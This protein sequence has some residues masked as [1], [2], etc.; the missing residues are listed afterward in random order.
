MNILNLIRYKNLLMIAIVQLLI[1]YALFEPFGVAITLNGFGFS[2][3]VIATL[4]LAAGGNIINDIYDKETDAINKPDKVIVGKTVSEK[5]AYNLFIAFNVIGVGVGFYLSHLVGRSGFFVLFVGI[6]GLLYLYA[7]YF[8]QLILVG[9]LLVSILVA[10]SI[11]IVGLFELL[12]A[13]TPE[14]QATQVTFF[15]IL[16]DY[17]LFAFI[18]N[19]LREMVKDIE[20]IDGDHKAGMNTLPIALGRE[21]AKKIVFA[22]SFVPIAATVY[23]VVT[24]LFKQQLVVAYFLLFIIAPLIYVSIKIFTAE[25]K[26]DYHAISNILKLVMLFGMLSLLLYKFILIN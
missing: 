6:S 10:L 24:Y 25:T 16:W 19:L 8:K 3:L 2:L 4:C 7:S 23:Y 5:T 21:R 14:N 15:K 22:L 17:A 12:P 18:I 20:D 9:N 1:K 11:I 13:I 26:K